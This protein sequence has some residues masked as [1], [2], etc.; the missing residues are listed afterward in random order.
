MALQ[1]RAPHPVPVEEATRPHRV[2]DL[3]VSSDAAFQ[4]REWV[5]QRVGW[6]IML[7]ILAVSFTGL[8]GGYG[9]LNQHVVRGE[10]GVTLELE[11]VVR[12]SGEARFAV[13]LP[14]ELA[15]DGNVRIW[16]DR[17]WLQGM[18]MEVTPVPEPESSLVHG[19]RIYYEF[20][21]TDPDRPGRVEFEF[22]PDAIGLRK[23]SFGVDEGPTMP[24]T[25]IVLP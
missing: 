8:L 16:I 6:V 23:G 18:T 15:P 13:V 4:Q 12:H 10:R 3:E 21:T 25:Q 11:R 1:N 14:P 2:G 9:P 22:K 20:S 24:F 5:M 19:E 17:S 7:V